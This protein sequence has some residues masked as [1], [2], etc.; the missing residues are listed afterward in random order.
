MTY[1]NLFFSVSLLQRVVDYDQ[2]FEDIYQIRA[3]SNHLYLNP[4]KVF[5]IKFKFKTCTN[6]GSI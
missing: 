1:L 3:D 2:L 5:L 4:K 6:D